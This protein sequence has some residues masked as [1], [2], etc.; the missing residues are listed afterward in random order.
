MKISTVGQAVQK[1]V[2]SDWKALKPTLEISDVH[3]TAGATEEEKA[4]PQ[5]VPK[6]DQTQLKSE[7]D[8][9]CKSFER[10]KDDHR[11]NLR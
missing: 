6:R 9:A 1:G 2:E 5:N 4:K 3:P 8:I 11:Q 7:W 10:R